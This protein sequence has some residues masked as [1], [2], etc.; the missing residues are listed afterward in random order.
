MGFLAAWLKN[1]PRVHRNPVEEAVMIKFLYG[2]FDD[3]GGVEER[4]ITLD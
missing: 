3:R 1:V 4:Q 2:I